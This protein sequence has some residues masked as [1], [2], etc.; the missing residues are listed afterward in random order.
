M[1]E[2]LYNLCH[3]INCFSDKVD[4]CEILIKAENEN[5]EI[6]DY[7]YI[8]QMDTLKEFLYQTLG[9]CENEKKCKILSVAV[10]PICNYWLLKEF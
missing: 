8:A 5:D 7:T 3:F 6:C 9:Q 2:L 10:R 4:T 1:D